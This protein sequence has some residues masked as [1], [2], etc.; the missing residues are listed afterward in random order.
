MTHLNKKINLKDVFIIIIGTFFTS[1]A[2]NMVFDPWELD[3]GGVTG[4]AIV[5]KYASAELF[6]YSVPVWL[7]TIA[8]NIPLFIV[9]IYKKGW[10]LIQ[11]TLFST[12]MLTA[13]LYIVPIFPLLEDKMVSVLFGGVLSGAGM[14][15]IFST[16]AT[17]GGTDL[18]S[19]L[20]HSRFRHISLP[21]ILFVTD[22][23]I[24]LLG[25]FVFGLENVIYSI[26]VVFLVS[27]ISD[28]IL[29]GMKLARVAYIVS[30]K[31]QE[32]SDEILT[33]LDRGVTGITVKGMYSGANKNMLFVAVD[34]KQIVEVTDIV[35]KHD[36]RAFMVICDAKE[37][38]G[39]GFIERERDP[40]R[41]S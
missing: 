38:L 32:I 25:V 16:M 27:K 10:K 22:G 4:L 17:T 18:F 40:D 28:A 12:L 11:K 41:I 13:W 20:L 33:D 7:T 8:L 21:K 1:I 14:G 30:D 24:V 37:V 19:D 35:Y 39:E 31:A 6:G 23:L 9:A 34:K 15:L 36:P 5:V 3:T 29:E 2:I 26:V